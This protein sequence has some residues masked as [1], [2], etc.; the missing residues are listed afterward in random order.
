[1][2]KRRW[3]KWNQPIEEKEAW[4]TGVSREER[5][6]NCQ[7]KEDLVKQWKSQRCRVNTQ[8]V[9]HSWKAALQLGRIFMPSVWK[10]AQTL[11]Q[12]LLRH[13]YGLQAVKSLYCKHLSGTWGACMVPVC[14]QP[15]GGL[16]LNWRCSMGSHTWGSSSPRL[17]LHNPRTTRSAFSAPF[18][19]E[20]KHH[21]WLHITP[22]SRYLFPWSSS[23]DR[24]MKL[25]LWLFAKGC[26]PLPVYFSATRKGKQGTGQL[27]FPPFLTFQRI[28]RFIFLTCGFIC[29]SKYIKSNIGFGLDG[30]W[31]EN[32]T[33]FQHF[34]DHK[35]LSKGCN[36]SGISSKWCGK[37]DQMMTVNIN[38]V[39][40]YQ[41]TRSCH[42]EKWANMHCNLHKIESILCKSGGKSSYIALSLMHSSEG[43]IK[44]QYVRVLFT[45]WFSLFACQR[46]AETIDFH[47]KARPKVH[48]A[49]A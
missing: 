41:L 26:F 31:R 34:V 16:D 13:F 49:I 37:R 1:M 43:H 42:R 19:I 46:G 30:S 9:A 7:W 11:C 17:L 4:L 38:Y 45:T 32:K 20:S 47:M 15:L 39:Q 40:Q 8:V 33:F 24:A 35:K 2:G 3:G 6:D 5:G 14:S 18:P 23:T 22:G 48:L 10:L 28:H 29:Q 27:L 25:P 44:V 21:S 36:Y 12:L